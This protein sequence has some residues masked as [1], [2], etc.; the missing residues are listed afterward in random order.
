MKN[1]A[2]PEF[3][4]PVFA[5]DSVPGSFEIF[6]FGR[7][8][9]LD[10]AE[11]RVA[12]AAARAVRILGVRAPELDHEVVDHAVEVQAVVEAL[13]ASLMKLPAVIGIL[14]RRSRR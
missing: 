5:I 12:G 7:V 1:C 4:R 6:A 2:P 14:S 8:L 3:G 10:V 9:V 13:F 11:R